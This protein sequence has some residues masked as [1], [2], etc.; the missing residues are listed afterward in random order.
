MCRRTIQNTHLSSQWDI[1][2]SALSQHT[3]I[4]FCGTTR[5][6]CTMQHL[7]SSSGS[8]WSR[9]RR[10]VRTTTTAWT[11][12][13]CRTSGSSHSYQHTT[14]AILFHPVPSSCSFCNIQYKYIQ[15][16][17][18]FDRD[19]SHILS[20]A[21]LDHLEVRAVNDTSR[22][23]TFYN[24]R[25]RP[26]I[27]PISCWNWGWKCRWQLYWRWGTATSGAA[28]CR[29]SSS[30]GPTSRSWRRTPSWRCSVSIS[31][32]LKALDMI[33]LRTCEWDRMPV[34]GCPNCLV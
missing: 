24:A 31:T 23:L 32:T 18:T 20:S 7:R 3:S 17:E 11:C 9:R 29:L 8:S 15:K 22:N 1:H 34:L 27:G 33:T 13:G 19:R 2:L 21:G 6:I 16:M 14:N 26:L 28:A 12:T 5:N 4:K 10:S 25:R 30:P